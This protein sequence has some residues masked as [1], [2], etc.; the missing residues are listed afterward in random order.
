M[1]D[2]P[3]FWFVV[4]PEFI[5]ELGRPKSTVALQDRIAGKIILKESEVADLKINPTLFGEA[6]AEA[7]VY[8]Y[9]KNFRPTTQSSPTGPSD[10][11]PDSTRNHT[12]ASRILKG[13]LN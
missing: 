5:Y 12:H 13:Q 3:D 9:A 4:I 10:S 8:K 7:E 11:H 1:T 6:E 2:P